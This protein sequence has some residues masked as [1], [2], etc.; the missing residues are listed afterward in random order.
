MMHRTVTRAV[1]TRPIDEVFA[2]VTT[3]GFWPQCS[4]V[5]RHIES[6]D[7]FS[8][9]R[10]GDAFREHVHI[11][12][13]RGFIDWKVELLDAPHRCVLAG[14]SSGEGFVSRLTGHDEVRLELTLAEA[15]QQTQLTREIAFH[16]GFAEAIGNVLGFGKALDRAAHIMMTTTVSML[17][18]PLLRG[19]SPDVT[20]ESLLH[21]ADPLADDAVASLISPTGDSTALERFITGLYR[22]EPPPQDLP[23]P[24]RRFFDVTATLPSWACQPRLEAASDVFLDWGVLAVGAHICASLPETY[25]MPRVAKLLNLTRELD[26]D[27]VHADRRL[28][29]TV[30]MCFDVLAQNGLTAKGEG[31]LALQRLRLIHAV[32]RF[33]VQHRMETPH[34]LAKLASTA[35]WDTEHGQPVSQL[36]LLHTLLTFSHVVVRS[37]EALG[38][39]LTPYEAESYIHIWNVAGAQLG[40]DPHLLP[41]DAADA[42][43]MFEAIKKRYAA[44]TPDAVALG[45]ALVWFWSSLFPA[46]LRDEGRELMQFVISQ[47]ISPE[48]A[49]MN[50]LDTLPA[51]S[52][53]AAN[54][55]KS[56]LE[57]VGRLCS[58][59]FEDVPGARQAAALC[60]SMLMRART[61][62]FERESGTFDIP[63]ELYERWRGVPAAS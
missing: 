57:V 50:G 4:P 63:Q 14:R 31:L 42:A 9:L 10:G 34:R 13:W 59:A 20:A 37:L 60:V 12:D 36:E 30:R 17:E 5:T 16:V 18:N 51:F 2:W 27:P 62:A 6:S 25:V 38:A 28:W 35:L 1:V 21:I 56:A 32:I 44:P 15:G 33:F 43:A 19:P 61:D 46:E 39:E 11:D 47:L 8:P 53:A 7:P 52:P 29:F 24:V 3:P 45:R 41:R 58:C 54:K 55:V 49:K 40:I 22:G 48:T 23:E 26:A